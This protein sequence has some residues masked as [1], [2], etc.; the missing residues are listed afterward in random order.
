MPLLKDI[1]LLN[2]FPKINKTYHNNPKAKSPF[3]KKK[4]PTF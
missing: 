1:N 3:L 4:Y 2:I